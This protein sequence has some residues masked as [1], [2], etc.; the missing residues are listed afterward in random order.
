MK[1]ILN[2]I[3]GEYVESVSGEWLDNTNPATGEVYSQVTNSNDKDV[4]NAIKAAKGAQEN[5]TRTSVEKRVEIIRKM[6]T[7]IKER[8]EELALM[9]TIDNGKPISVS[10]SVDIPRASRNFEFFAD[11]MTQYSTDSYNEHGVLNYVKRYPLGIVTC[12]SPWNLPMY[13]FTWKIAPALITGNCVLAKPSEVTPMTASILGEIANKAGMPAGVLNIIHGEGHRVGDEL[14]TNPA[15]KA[16]SFTGSTATG[17]VIS[18]LAGEHL[19]KCSLEMGGKN[20]N[21]IFDDCDYNKA[22]STSVAAA[23]ANQGQ[24]C[25]CGSRIFVEKSI[26]EKFKNDFVEKAKSLA[27]KQ[28]DPQDP[29]TRQGALVSE[30]HFNKVMSCIQQAVDEGGKILCGGER[31]GDKGFFV[32]PT[33]IEGLSHECVTNQE[34]IFGPVGV[35]IPFETEEEAIIMANS[36]KYGLGASLWTENVNKAHRVADKIDSGIV[37]INTWMLRDLR[38]PFGGMKESGMGREGGTYSLNFFTEPKNIC[39]KFNGDL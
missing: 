18:K 35:L 39:L 6:A 28:G 26:Y 17:K 38:I 4:L 5:W 27:S 9:E 34:E 14:V 16:V 1:K 20:P 25:L 21:I 12:I 3:N 11:V 29:K 37:W 23:F 15:V 32:Q 2:F 8:E 13:L 24:I 31:H 22:L 19:K 7:L 30:A 33:V 10:S 36:T